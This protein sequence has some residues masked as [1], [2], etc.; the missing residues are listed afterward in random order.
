M[1][2]Q[3]WQLKGEEEEQAGPAHPPLGAALGQAVQ[4][5]EGLGQHWTLLQVL[6]PYI[7]SICGTRLQYNHSIVGPMENHP[8]NHLC[9]GS[10][11]FLS[12]P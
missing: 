2:V 8:K 1:E 5:Q 12:V 9:I 7:S 4:L 6:K 3:R 10:L 11:S